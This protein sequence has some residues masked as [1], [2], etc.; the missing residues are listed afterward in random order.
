MALTKFA[1]MVWAENNDFI[2][3]IFSKQIIDPFFSD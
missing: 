2:L 1:I 3:I